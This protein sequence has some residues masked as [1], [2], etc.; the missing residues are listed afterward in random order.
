[1]L[2]SKSFVKKTKKG[3]VL[4]VVREHYLRDDIYSGSPLDPECIAS[5]VKLSDSA[6]H[7]L[8]IDTNVALHQMDFLEHSAIDDV[9]VCSVVLEEVK[10][11]NQSIYQRLRDLCAA[12][13]KRFF[14][15]ANEHHR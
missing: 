2:Q 10:N 8:L 12:E 6:S 9:I 14:V 15:F 4:K 11:K 7:Y 3:Q 1:M 5:A 13:N